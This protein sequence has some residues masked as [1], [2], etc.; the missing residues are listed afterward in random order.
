MSAIVEARAKEAKS[1]F[2]IVVLTQK[3]QKCIDYSEP[4]FGTR[5]IFQKSPADEGNP[6]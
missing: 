3:V 4:F 5:V 1:R 2:V 6:K